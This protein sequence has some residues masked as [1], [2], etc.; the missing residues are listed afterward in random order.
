MIFHVYN[1]ISSHK[2]IKVNDKLKEWINRNH[3]KHGEV[4]ANKVKVH[5]YLEI[6]FDFTE[7]VKVEI[8]MDDYFERMINDFSMKIS[9]SGTDLTQEKCGVS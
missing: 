4:K 7:K 9:K 3:D 2:N 5:E 6:T 8:K 1:V